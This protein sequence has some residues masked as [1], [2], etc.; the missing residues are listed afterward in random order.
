LNKKTTQLQNNFPR[1]Y[2]GAAVAQTTSYGKAKLFLLSYLQ[3]YLF[4]TQVS[5]EAQI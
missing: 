3:F 1:S 2:Y 4:C 5:H